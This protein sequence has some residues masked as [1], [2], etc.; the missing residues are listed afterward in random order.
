MQGGW[1]G[2][3][4]T[5]EES[6]VLLRSCEDIRKR[7]LLASSANHDARV[8]K[9]KRK[10]AGNKPVNHLTRCGGYSLKSGELAHPYGPSYVMDGH[11]PMSGPYQ[12][13][14]DPLNLSEWH[15]QDPSRRQLE[16]NAQGNEAT[17]SAPA[18]KQSASEAAS[19]R[20]TSEFARAQAECD[21]AAKDKQDLLEATMNATTPAALAL[22][23]KALD[24]KKALAALAN[25]E[26]REK[27]KAEDA[28]S[29]GVANSG[30]EA[31]PTSPASERPTMANIEERQAIASIEHY[32]TANP[33]APPTDI[34]D[35]K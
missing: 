8:E 29:A 14:K 11:P 17:A 19:E 1:G 31:P 30:E 20:R 18:E 4:L 5:E 28:A 24:E 16:Q 26:K 12:L 35:P 13:P 2:S 23:Y 34:T 33:E 7:A 9:K 25:R 10:L 32:S 15:D 6:E 3:S 27:Q 22:A 21:A